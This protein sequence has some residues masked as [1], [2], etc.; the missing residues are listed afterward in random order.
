MSQWNCAINGQKYG[1]V[2]EEDLKQ[3]IEQ[4]RLS[5]SDMVWTDGMAEWQKAESVPAFSACFAAASNVPPISGIPSNY[6]AVAQE[7]APGAVAS[8]VCGIVGCMV[9][10]T[11]LILGIIALNNYKK[12]MASIHRFPQKYGGEGLC[13]AGKVTGIIAIVMGSFF[14]LYFLFVF[15][16]FASVGG[17]AGM[18]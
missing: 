12:A 5:P 4:K 18:R 3:W 7:N 14:V 15:I 10:C 17:A 13:T 8:M 2:S 1:P 6:A 9:P 16:I 11:G